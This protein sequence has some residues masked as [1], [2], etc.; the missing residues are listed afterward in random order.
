[1][2]YFISGKLVEKDPTYVVIETGGIGYEI[3]ISLNTFSHIKNIDACKLYTYFYVKEDMQALYGFFEL[4]EKILFTKLISIS[5]IGPSTGLML[6][7][8]LSTSEVKEAILS[9]NV[10][11]IQ[12]VKGIG[13]KTA[14]RVI[15]ELKDKIGKEIGTTGV[16]QSVIAAATAESNTKNEALAALISL[17]ISKSVA[18]KN[19]SQIIKKYGNELSLEELIKLA[20][21]NN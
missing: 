20:L 7:S 8:S 10:K 5:G 13:A 1:M 2:Y 18:E 9:G 3:K 16:S 4:E 17:G 15:L 6:F 11:V 14:Q 12:S 19:I 21:K